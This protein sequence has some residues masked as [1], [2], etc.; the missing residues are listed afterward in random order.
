M[1]SKPDDH[2]NVTL[3]VSSSSNVCHLRMLAVGGGGRTY[4]WGGA[5]SG[6]VL[7]HTETLTSDINH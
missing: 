2:I 5:G 3:A 7:Y 1:L 6:Y 4:G